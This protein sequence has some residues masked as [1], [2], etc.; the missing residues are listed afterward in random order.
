VDTINK[1]FG[2]VVAETPH[3]YGIQTYNR[4]IPLSDIV[5]KQSSPP[6]PSSQKF[7][8]RIFASLLVP[9][10]PKSLEVGD[11]V[12]RSTLEDRRSYPWKRVPL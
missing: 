9:F 10:S 6:P 8:S 2:Q 3:H 12:Y 4:N 5:S 7:L 1:E 11:W